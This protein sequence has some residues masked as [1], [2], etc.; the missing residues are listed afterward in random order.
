MITKKHFH[1][2]PNLDV[3]SEKRK[4]SKPKKGLW[5]MLKENSAVPAN[6]AQ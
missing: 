6:A 3:E 4:K 5:I 2:I 1:M